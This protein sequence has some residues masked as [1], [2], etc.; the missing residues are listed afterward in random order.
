MLVEP[1][2]LAG[3]PALNWFGVPPDWDKEL[4]MIVMMEAF[5]GGVSQDLMW[6]S[7]LISHPPNV[8]SFVPETHDDSFDL[9]CATGPGT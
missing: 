9:C 7:V 6:S 2:P 5:V 4:L 3:A 1:D 8:N